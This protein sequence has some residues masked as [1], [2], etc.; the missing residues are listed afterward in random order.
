MQ[1]SLYL[2]ILKRVFVRVKEGSDLSMGDELEF[3]SNCGGTYEYLV[4]RMRDYIDGYETDNL[5]KDVYA[6]YEKNDRE[7]FN[8]I[9]KAL[10]YKNSVK[11]LEPDM[12]KTIYE[13]NM[14]MTVSKLETYA[15]CGFR[16][17]L[18]NVLRPK[19]RPVQK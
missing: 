11:A 15:E 4:A 3:V 5:W 14:T 10:Q 8:I 2:D 6:W 13:N 16:Y 9:N 7:N 17:F 19:E 18:E 12:V 1:P